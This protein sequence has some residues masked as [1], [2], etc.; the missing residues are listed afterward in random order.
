MELPGGS[1]FRNDPEHFSPCVINSEV[2]SDNMPW[3]LLNFS[4]A[5]QSASNSLNSSAKSTDT[6]RHFSGGK[7][8]HS[9]GATFTGAITHSQH[10]HQSTYFAKYSKKKN[11]NGLFTSEIKHRRALHLPI[12]SN[13]A[14]ASMTNILLSILYTICN[15]ASPLVTHKR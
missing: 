12:N 8:F 1:T 7:M 10:A 15:E 2:P 4:C 3:C 14:T 11:V 6:E 9:G 13:G 5:T